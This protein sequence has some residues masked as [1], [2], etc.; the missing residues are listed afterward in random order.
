LPPASFRSFAIAL[1]LSYSM[2]GTGCDRVGKKSYLALLDTGL[3]VAGLVG[4]KYEAC[5]TSGDHN[6]FRTS[7][8]VARAL[9][10]A[11]PA[12]EERG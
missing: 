9:I 12:A 3:L 11:A 4:G 10:F 1:K 7:C 2:L 6:L 8:L 5:V